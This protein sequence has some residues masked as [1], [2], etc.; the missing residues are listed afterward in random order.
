[1]DRARMGRISFYSRLL[2]G[3]VVVL[4]L[5]PSITGVDAGISPH[6]T[7]DDTSVWDTPLWLQVWLMGVVLPSFLSSLFFLRRSREARLALGGFVVSHLP[8]MLGL[9]ETTVGEVAI[10]HLFCYSPALISLARRRSRVA[11][12]SPFGIW[13]HVML[14]VLSISLAFDLR[15]SVRF[16]FA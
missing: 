6:Q 11:P 1:M 3:A 2:F 12:G 4:M 8:M 14:V 5:A 10:I 7:W 9:F 15:D 16:L 13:V